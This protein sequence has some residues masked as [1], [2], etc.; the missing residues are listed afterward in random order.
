[1]FAEA[2]R[3]EIVRTL[4][5][6]AHNLPARSMITPALPGPLGLKSL[7]RQEGVPDVLSVDS[8]KNAALALGSNVGDTFANIEAALRLLED[9]GLVAAHPGGRIEIVDTSFLYET[10]PMYF[11]NQPKFINGACLVWHC[12]P[13]LLVVSHYLCYTGSN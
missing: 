3:V 7:L 4:K 1:V 12:A 13:L 11:S 5:D 8:L 6:Y 9:P 2:A 10:E